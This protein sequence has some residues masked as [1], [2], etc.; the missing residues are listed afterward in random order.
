MISCDFISYRI[1]LPSEDLLS[2]SEMH[3]GSYSHHIVN[4]E[5]SA[6][7][8]LLCINVESYLTFQVITKDYAVLKLPE[9][10]L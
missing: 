8:K 1:Y 5:I 4:K 3:Y 10:D 6:L 2:R 9:E 7:T